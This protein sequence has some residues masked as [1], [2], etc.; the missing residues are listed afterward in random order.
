MMASTT[1]KPAADLSALVATKGTAAP[2]KDMTTRSSTPAADEAKGGTSGEPLNFRVPAEFR[3]RF[4]TYAAQHDM[5]LNE[6]LY[7]AFD[8][9]V[10]K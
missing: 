6:L 3:R 8:A 10:K 2:T 4:K 1:K 5:K 7:K 9:Y